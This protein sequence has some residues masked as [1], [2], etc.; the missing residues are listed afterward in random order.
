[1]NEIPMDKSTKAEVEEK[2]KGR[3]EVDVKA[4]QGVKCVRGKDRTAC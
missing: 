3:L 4:E 2:G 1:M